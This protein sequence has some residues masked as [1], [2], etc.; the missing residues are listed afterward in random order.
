MQIVA[1]SKYIH[2]SPRKLRLVAGQVRGLGAKEA[3][4]LLKNLNKRAALPI[5]LVLK[6]GV[7]NAVNNFQLNQSSLKVKALEV[8]EGPRF[9]R[10]DKSHRAFRW[11]TIQKKT[12]HIRMVLEGEKEK[13]KPKKTALKKKPASKGRKRLSLRKKTKKKDSKKT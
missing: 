2:Q 13:V 8:G 9:K 11:G 10:Q 6:Q 7:G 4:I 1:K 3:E 12:A 5:L